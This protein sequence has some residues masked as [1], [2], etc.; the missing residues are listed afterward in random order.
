[1]AAA[2][3]PRPALPGG[4][5][6]PTSGVMTVLDLNGVAIHRALL[7]RP[8][9]EALAEAVRAVAAAAPLSRY[10]TPTGRP[11]SVRMTAAGALGWTSGPA[12]YAYAPL[13]PATGRPWPPIPPQALAVWRAVAGW[14]QDPDSLLVN[15]YGADARMGLH[16]DADEAD[17]G[18]PVVSVSLGDPA[19]FRVG[20]LRRGG[21]TASLW[22]ESGDV[23]VLAG[24]ARL[25]YHGVDRI[26]FGAS[27]L[28]PR[29]GRINL[30]LRVAGGAARPR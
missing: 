3:K 15:W 11:M 30:T 1:M 10:V 29:G 24:A 6:G 18:A 8:A 16:R 23:A 5:P 14:P 9:Q 27:S 2:A 26:R 25:A 28:L 20:G 17:L 13:C 19:Q 4:A 22:L 12:G 7:D 21:P